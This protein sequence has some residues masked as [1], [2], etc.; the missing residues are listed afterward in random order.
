MECHV[1]IWQMSPQLSCRDICQIR[2]WFENSNMC[3]CK[4]KYVPN[5]ENNKWSFSNPHPWTL[6]NDQ[7]AENLVHYCVFKPYKCDTPIEI[8]T[9]SLLKITNIIFKCITN[10]KKCLWWQILCHALYRKLPTSQSVVKPVITWLSP[11]Q[12][13]CVC[14]CMWG[15]VISGLGNGITNTDFLV[16]FLKTNLNLRF[17]N[18]RKI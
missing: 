6:I 8:P 11:L 16:G 13:M 9:L 5:G 7:F 14:V 3:F 12:P 4:I 2:M 15:T 10:M 18:F 1:H 17:I